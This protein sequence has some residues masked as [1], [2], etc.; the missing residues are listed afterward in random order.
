MRKEKMEKEL[1]NI[2]VVYSNYQLHFKGKPIVSQNEIAS[3]N[4]FFSLCHVFWKKKIFI[5]FS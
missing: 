1:T 3:G 4:H 5:R 2:P